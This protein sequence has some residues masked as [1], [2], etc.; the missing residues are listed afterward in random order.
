MAHP[1]SD[2]DFLVYCLQP[3]AILSS[4]CFSA[5]ISYTKV[6]SFLLIQVTPWPY[7]FLLPHWPTNIIPAHPT[8]ERIYFMVTLCFE[9]WVLHLFNKKSGQ[10]NEK[11]LFNS[12]IY[13]FALYT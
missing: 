2:T 11:Y 8:V 10:N 1:F 3:E 9:P 5:G 13:N 4:L 7:F 12:E 6:A